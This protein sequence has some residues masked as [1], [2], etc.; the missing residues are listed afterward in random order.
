MLTF[1]LNG[2]SCIRPLHKLFLAGISFGIIGL[3]YREVTI[4]GEDF[5]DFK[6]LMDVD[7]PHKPRYSQVVRAFSIRMFLAIPLFAWTNI[8][9]E[10]GNM[11]WGIFLLILGLIVGA[12][13]LEFT[14][15]RCLYSEWERKC[16]QPKSNNTT[17]Q[18]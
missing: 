5:R 13:I 10:V 6:D 8:A 18:P 11:Y 15:R 17:D 2:T 12:Q 16:R 7:P 14:K 4:F 9:C 3:L 1:S